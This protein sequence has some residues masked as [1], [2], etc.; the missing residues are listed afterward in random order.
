MP[1]TSTGRASRP[2]PS[3]NRKRGELR[4]GECVE[5][6]SARLQTECVE[7]GQA[8]N[9][10]RPNRRRCGWPEVAHPGD[11]VSETGSQRRDGSRKRDPE[12]RPAA[13]KPD[14]RAIS[15]RQIHIFPPRAREHPTKFAIAQCP[16]QGNCAPND[17]GPDERGRRTHVGRNEWTHEKN[18]GAHDAPHHEKRRVDHAEATP[19]R[20]SVVRRRERLERWNV[21][22]RSVLTVRTARRDEEAHPARSTRSR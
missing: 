19:R 17:P 20:V 6:D 7:E 11:A 13:Q 4:G 16:G 15:F 1:G 14:W 2:S 3:K 5:N 12:T 21:A 10:K 22:I 8:A 18:P 9:R